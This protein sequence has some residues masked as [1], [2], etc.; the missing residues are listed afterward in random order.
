MNNYRN[1]VWQDGLLH[2]SS[3]HE[4]WTLDGGTLGPDD[5]SYYYYRSSPRSSLK[6]RCSHILVQSHRRTLTRVYS[7]Y[8]E[9]RSSNKYSPF[10]L[11]VFNFRPFCNTTTTGIQNSSSTT[12][13]ASFIIDNIQLSWLR[14]FP[15]FRQKADFRPIMGLTPLCTRLAPSPLIT[16]RLQ[17]N[18]LFLLVV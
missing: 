15:P 7:T 2:V 1:R 3:A 16:L 8:I 5:R 14:Q 10:A 9:V 18:Y 12:H 6:P 13:Y 17:H 4:I 11:R